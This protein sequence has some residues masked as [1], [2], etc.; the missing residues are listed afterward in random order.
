VTTLILTIRP[1]PGCSATVEA[2]RE[3]G[4]TIEGYPLFAI[5]PVAWN[6]PSPETI[7][8]L[9]LGSANAVRHAG[10]A[11]EQYRGKPVYSVGAAT[12]KAAEA[13]GFS[14]AVC[15]QGVLQPVLDTLAGQELRLLR[16]TGAEHVPLH[17]PVG[18]SVE[19]RIAY[20]SIGLPLP[21]ALAGRLA[22]GSLVLVH[23]AAAARHFAAE[24]DRCGVPRNRV[25]MAVLGPRIADAAGDGWAAVRSAAVPAEAALLALASDMCHDLD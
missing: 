17:P 7:D 18:I 23:S 9:L 11:L 21:D 10:S 5:R 16:V 8:A 2:G 22:S 24:C 6:P 13:A 15:G 25:A 14:V 19:T 20:E 1:E 4:L 12:G 3:V